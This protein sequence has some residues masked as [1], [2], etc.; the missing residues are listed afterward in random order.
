MRLE[1][2]TLD[3]ALAALV[4]DL[5]AKDEQV[6]QLAVDVSRYKQGMAEL[7]ATRVRPGTSLIRMA[8]F[9]SVT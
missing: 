2:H 5:Q 1:N 8:C 3:R 9:E 6:E 4:A 7:G